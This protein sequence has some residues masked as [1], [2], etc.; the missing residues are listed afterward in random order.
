MRGQLLI[1]EIKLVFYFQSDFMS[2]NK[3]FIIWRALLSYGCTS[4]VGRAFKNLD[5][6]SA[7]GVARPWPTR[8][9]ARPS[10]TNIGVS[11]NVFGIFNWKIHD[12]FWISWY[13]PFKFGQRMEFLCATFSPTLKI[14]A[15]CSQQ[16]DISWF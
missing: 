5:F 13:Q 7:S 16:W 8:A 9:Q 12:K 6:L 4:E 15:I 2:E 1:S 11:Q 14:R 3:W 10:A